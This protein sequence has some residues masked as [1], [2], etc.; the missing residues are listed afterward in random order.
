V[1]IL[2]VIDDSGFM[3]EEQ[4]CLARSF[5]D[6]ISH[7]NVWK[8]DYHIGAISVNVVDEAVIGRLNRG[9][10]KVTPRYLTP[11][12]GGNFAKMVQY[13]SQGGS[14]SQE[15]GLQ[16]AQT[17]LS[18]PL[19]TDTGVPCSTTANCTSDPNI[20]PDPATCGYSCVDGRCGGYNAGFLRENA[21][22]EVVMLSDEEDQSSAGTAF[23]IDFFKNIKG[24]YNVNMM[25]VNAI[26]GIE[27]VPSAPVQSEGD[28]VASDGGTADEGKRYLEVAQQTGGLTDSI[29]Q[30][31]YGPIM[32][33]IG[34]VSFHPKVQFFLSRLA[35]PATV[36]VQVAGQ[37][38][39]AGWRYDA[40]S[41]SVVFDEK[42]PCMPQPGQKI[43]IEYDTLCLTS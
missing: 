32:N 43:R 12:S 9:D 26:V 8:N 7:A 34:N 15:A 38:C 33:Q 18:A 11:T 4:T 10:D 40:P 23:Y 42:G 16:A 35:D 41:N 25:H 22:L 30:D 14:D 21:Q 20:C 36:T 1:D 31:S 13:G 29:C 39:T 2:F 27:G 17:A 3:F 6:F 24:W 5:G 37:T 19:A 28:C